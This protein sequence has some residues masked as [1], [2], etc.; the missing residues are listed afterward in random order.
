MDIIQRCCPVGYSSAF[1]S[2]VVLFLVFW[3]G[4]LLIPAWVLAP[5]R[6]RFPKVL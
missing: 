6:S 1:L 4:F 5:V 3:I 2:P